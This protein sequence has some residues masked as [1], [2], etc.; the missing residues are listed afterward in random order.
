[1][2]LLSK[3]TL[4]DVD[5]ANK[6]VIVRFDFNCPV[7]DGIVTSDKRIRAALPTIKFLLEKN[8]KIVALSHLSRIKTLDDIKSNKKS[9]E[10]VAKKLQEILPDVKVKFEPSTDFINVEN[11]VKGMQ[12]KEILVLQNTRYYDVD[13]EGVVNKLESKNNSE[14]AKFWAGLGDVFVNDAFGTAHRAHAS[15][16]GIASIVKDSCVGFLVEEELTKIL[17]A[18][19]DPTRPYVAILGGAKVSDKLKVINNLLPNADK[20][21]ICGG[22]AY[23]FHKALGQDIGHSLLEEDMVPVAKEIMEKGKDKIVLTEDCVCNKAFEDTPGQVIEF[24][25]PFNGLEGLDIG[26]KSIAKFQNA[27]N[28][29][30]TVVWNG[31]AGVFEFKNYANGTKSIIEKLIEIT[32]QG[33]Y[34]LIGGGDSAASITALGFNENDFSFVSTGGGASLEFLEG[35]ELPGIVALDN[36]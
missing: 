34:T 21:I 30:K 10:P 22:M 28:G 32:K 20:I 17:K 25:Q 8:C 5:V 13:P 24:G 26:P 35:K 29:A 15:N 31:P 18:I 27:L 11:A 14:L 16:A 1:M 3:K 19:N 4:H 9:L 12:S 2:D 33:A 7:K 6:T 36:K 23:T